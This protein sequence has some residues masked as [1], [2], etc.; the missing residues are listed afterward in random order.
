MTRIS[1]TNRNRNWAA[2]HTFE[3]CT[4]SSDFHFKYFRLGIFS[5]YNFRIPNA[6]KGQP[7]TIKSQ[8]NQREKVPGYRFQNCSPFL[9]R[10]FDFEFRLLIFSTSNIFFIHFRIPNPSKAQPATTKSKQKQWEKVPGYRFQNCWPFLLRN[11]EFE[12]GLLIFSTSNIFF[13]HFRIPNAS[14]GQPATTKSQ[15]KQRRKRTWI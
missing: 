1:A 12:F 10:N 5:W 7:A 15:Q 2:T 4:F 8:Q 14:Q 13:I 6:S 3:T 11:F 9:L